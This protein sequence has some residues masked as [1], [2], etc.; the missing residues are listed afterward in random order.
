MTKQ[1]VKLGTLGNG[2]TATIYCRSVSTRNGFRHDAVMLIPGEPR[3]AAKA[4]Y[5]NRTWE[6]Y[7]FQSVLHELAEKFVKAK[8]GCKEIFSGKTKRLERLYEN[9]VK[10]IDKNRGGEYIMD[11]RMFD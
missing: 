4:H 8:T 2:E 11:E 10:R 1:K 6:S 7:Q 9:L 3:I 5:L